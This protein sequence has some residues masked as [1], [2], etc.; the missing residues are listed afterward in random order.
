MSNQVQNRFRLSPKLIFTFG[1][2]VLLFGLYFILKREPAPTPGLMSVSTIAEEQDD[3]I[4]KFVTIR[5]K[6]IEKLG[7]T[8]FVMRRK[9]FFFIKSEPVIIINASG[10]VFNL[11]TNEDTEVQVTGTVR[12]LDIAK[13]EKEFN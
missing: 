9:K 3:L 4:G 8:S 10:K 6:E 13:L 2:F 5:S 11:P 12:Q 1:F 7:P